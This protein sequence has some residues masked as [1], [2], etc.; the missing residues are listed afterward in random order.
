MQFRSL[1]VRNVWLVFS[2]KG[3]GRP[4]SCR[5]KKSYEELESLSPLSVC[6]YLKPSFNLSCIWLRH[7][8]QGRTTHGA[9]I[10]SS[11]RQYALICGQKLSVLG[12]DVCHIPSGTRKFISLGSLG[13]APSVRYM[14]CDL[15]SFRYLNLPVIDDFNLSETVHLRFKLGAASFAWLSS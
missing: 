3:K 4:S 11:S 9:Q 13:P 5:Q 7:S 6:R 10:L 8:D 12:T 1:R 14:S 2:P 15:P